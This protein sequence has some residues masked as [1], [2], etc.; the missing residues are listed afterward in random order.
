MLRILALFDAP[1]PAQRA[2]AALA[3][4]GIAP[5][6]V[7]SVPLIPGPALA[8]LLAPVTDLAAVRSALAAR[9]VP[10]PVGEVAVDAVRRGAI[11]VLVETPAASAARV[12][13]V[14]DGAGALHPPDL[15]AHW[16]AHPGTTYDWAAIAPPTVDPPAPPAP[17]LAFASPGEA[18]D[19]ARGA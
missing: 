13:T 17:T 1:V 10:A 15:E 2:L 8:R 6:D 12:V 18:D 16:R 4:E 11:L 14:L 9:D 3:A 5:G 19:L 7:W